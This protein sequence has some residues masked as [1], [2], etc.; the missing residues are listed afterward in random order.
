MMVAF[1][2][3][4]TMIQADTIVCSCKHMSSPAKSLIDKVRRI[5]VIMLWD[6]FIFVHF[7]SVKICVLVQLDLKQEN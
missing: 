3:A 5:E 2:K 6:V 7:I 1:V 4:A